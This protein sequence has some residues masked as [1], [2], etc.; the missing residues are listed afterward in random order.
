LWTASHRFAAARA[1]GLDEIPVALLDTDGLGDDYERSNRDM[2]GECYRDS[3]P[4]GMVAE[5]LRY[6]DPEAADLFTLD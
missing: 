3:I 4:E 2:L 1:A 5:A 6:S